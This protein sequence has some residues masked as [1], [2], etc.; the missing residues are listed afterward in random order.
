MSD[1][2]R[3]FTTSKGVVWPLQGIP[4]MLIRQLVTDEKGKPLPPIVDV[5]YGKKTVKESNPLDPAYKE[6]LKE[7]EVQHNARIMIFVLTRGVKRNPDKAALEWLT[8]FFP[9]STDSERKYAWILESMEGDIEAGEMMN[10]ILGITTPTERGIRDA[11]AIFPGD[12][13]SNGHQSLPI[14]AV[15]SDH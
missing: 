1:S 8:E 14:E 7:W 3:T 5:N 11:E 10:A 12:G 15:T 6:A 9:A 4:A 13:Q 2:V